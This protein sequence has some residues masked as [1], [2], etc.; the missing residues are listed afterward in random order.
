MKFSI[1]VFI[2]IIIIIIYAV[3]SRIVFTANE[4]RVQSTHSNFVLSF[5]LICLL[6]LNLFCRS[7][8]LSFFGIIFLSDRFS[9]CLSHLLRWY[10]DVARYWIFIL[11]R[12]CRLLVP[13]R[14]PFLPVNLPMQTTR[15]WKFKKWT[16]FFHHHV[17]C[18]FTF[19]FILWRDLRHRR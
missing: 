13:T 1:I 11:F 3:Y 7:T 6:R 17:D 2:I 18:S 5:F 9:L 10:G 19:L 8:F 14:D 15:R 16:L 12:F 4:Q